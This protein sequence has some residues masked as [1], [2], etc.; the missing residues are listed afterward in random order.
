MH[1]NIQQT[2]RLNSVSKEK[3]ILSDLE[4]VLSSTKK[5]GKTTKAKRSGEHVIIMIIMIIM[6]IMRMKITTRI[7]I[8]RCKQGIVIIMITDN[9]FRLP[10]HVI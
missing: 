1:Q 2:W 10:A 3:E 4:E 7:R 6:M 8:A 9:T 5:E